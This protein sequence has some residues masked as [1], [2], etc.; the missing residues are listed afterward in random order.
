MLDF[1][2]ANSGQHRKTSGDGAITAPEKDTIRTALNERLEQ[3][4]LDI[5][6]K[7]KQRQ[8]KYLVGDVLGGPGDS[9]ELL[10]SGAKVGLWTDRAT[11]EGGDIFDLIARY[12]SLDAKTQFPQV[13]DRARDWLG[14]VSSVPVGASVQNKAKA[15]AVDEL[16][17]ATA[18]WDYQDASGKLIAV[19]YR[20]DPEPGRKEFR[21]WDVLRRKMTPPERRPLYNQPG[22]FRAEQVVLVEGEK[23]AQA[24]ID[25]GV[26]AT[27]A[28]H[29]A[30][31]PVDKTDWSPLK[32]KHVLIWPDRDK[33]G[34]IYADQASQAVMQAGAISCAILQP[35]DGDPDGWDAADAVRD[36]FDIAGF[37][38][39]GERM[40]VVM[41]V[42]PNVPVVLIDG[43]DY[44]TEDG[45]ATAFTYQFAEDWRYCAPWGKWFV[46]NG[47]RWNIDKSLY[48]LHL[49]RLICRTAAG[50]ADAA[51][52]KSRL[53]SSGTI[54]AV[55]RLARTDPRHTARVESWDAY[56]WLLNTPGGI[57]VDSSAKLSQ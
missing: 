13:L 33:P 36:G 20:Y 27:T 53:S 16:G 24:L 1:N 51:K 28:M 10:L 5:W 2:D 17:P 14:R 56:A 54:S 41:S 49:S 57:V 8:N 39:V 18:K 30:N 9:L 31:A 11:G 22:M 35:P 47:V 50:H 6:P 4:V 7:G 55:E 32:G 29:G 46:W 12:Y 40:P 44:T 38:A 23:C 19:V 34:W 42:D 48:V 26:C 45:L 37:L 21:P 25:L 43:M 3:L 52:V 15:P